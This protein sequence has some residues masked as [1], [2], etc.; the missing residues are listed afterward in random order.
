MTKRGDEPAHP[1]VVVMGV[2]GAG[3]TTIGEAVASRL[4]VEYAD[5][6]AFHPQ[7]NIDKMSNGSPLTDEDR[8]PWLHAIGSWLNE[9][10]ATGGV[11]SCSALRRAYR[12]VLAGSAAGVTFL[13]LDGDPEMIRE[14]MARR[15]DHFMP[16]SLIDSQ[17]ETLEPLQDGE[18]GI[19]VDVFGSPEGIVETCLSELSR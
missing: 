4:N 15:S 9:R 19:V 10:Q 8:W 16:T 18:R 17:I 14:R 5:A 3:K 2:S 6:D 13:H 1:L 12:D 11:V 7:V